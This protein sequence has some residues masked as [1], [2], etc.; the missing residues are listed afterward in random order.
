MSVA[1]FT[2]SPH[3]AIAFALAAALL[4]PLVD[5]MVKML[6]QTYPVVVVA[7]ARFAVMSAILG[8]VAFAG[9]G[10]SLF[11]PYAM[12]VQTVRA[13]TAVLAT[14][15]FYAGLRTLPLAESTAIMCLGPA[16]ATGIAHVWLRERTTLAQWCGIAAS[17]AGALLIARPGGSVFTPAVVLPAAASL[18]FA[19]F[20]LSSRLAGRSDD[21]RVTTFWTCFG[22]FLLLSLAMPFNV[23]RVQAPPDL[24]VF[25]LVGLVGALGQLALAIAYRHGAT[26]LV[27]P[28]GYFSL[29][30]AAVLGWMLFHDT[31]HWATVAGMMLVGAGGIAVIRCA[32]GVVAR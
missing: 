31:V 21:P 22:G 16:L 24:S 30:V 23:E 3:R 4:L 15:L 9:L 7:W 11:Q 6:V 13:L 1:S 18:S 20:I 2:A 17:L 25:V 32:P 19:A 5:G 10:W 12:L 29:A 14:G 27:A 8:T 26:A 28:I